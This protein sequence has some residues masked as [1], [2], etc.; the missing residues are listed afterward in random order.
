MLTK[1]RN[2]LIILFLTFITP[3]HYAEK[4]DVLKTYA[5]DQF[6]ILQGIFIGPL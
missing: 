2:I 6:V 1:W 3:G 5:P 4:E